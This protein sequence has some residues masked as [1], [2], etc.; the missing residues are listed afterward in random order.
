MTLFQKATDTNAFLKM[1]I[2]GF[3]GSGKTMTATLTAI[4]LIEYMR[5][6]DMPLAQK[7]LFFLDTEQGSN[8]VRRRIEAAGIEL[9]TAKTRAFSDLLDAVDEAQ[10]SASVL[11]VDSLT[12]FWTELTT[13]YAKKQKRNRLYFEDWA[14]LKGEWRKFTDRFINTP[15]HCLLAGRAAFEYDYFENDAGKK[16]LEKTN[17]RMRAEGEMGYE[18]DLLVLMERDTDMETKQ[19]NHIATVMKDRST[20]LD[21]KKFVNPT[22]ASFLPHIAL[23]NL[24]GTQLGIDTSR[25]SEA[26]LVTDKKD[27]QPV[28][29]RIAVD[30]IQSL[31][32][33][34]IPGQAA[35]DKKRK[36]ELLRKHF[37]ASWTEIEEVMPLFELRAGYDSLHVELEGKPSRYGA[38]ALPAT[39]VTNTADGA[40]IEPK[41]QTVLQFDDD[42]PIFDSHGKRTSLAA[43]NILAAG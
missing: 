8:W 36:L 10:R 17:I 43:I 39:Q 5:E 27:W 23:L 4:G 37:N 25:T 1:G 18:P 28:Q 33:L 32:V 3:A 14:V 34:H 31:M 41:P 38:P 40:M 29:R 30:E 13:S 11:L 12:H 35:A 9:F 15:T 19:V 20:E 21:G 7:P 16:E 2:F 26:M 24:G 6:R 42:F 22:F